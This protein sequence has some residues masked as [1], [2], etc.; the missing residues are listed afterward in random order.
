MPLPP[1]S[2]LTAALNIGHLS[3]ATGTGLILSETLQRQVQHVTYEFIRLKEEHFGPNSDE[4]GANEW[5]LATRGLMG[6]VAEG[7]ARDVSEADLLKSS[8]LAEETLREIRSLRGTHHFFSKT[9]D[10][11]FA[12]LAMLG[13]DYD[14]FAPALLWE[15]HKYREKRDKEENEFLKD[16]HKYLAE[17]M[18]IVNHVGSGQGLRPFEIECR[19]KRDLMAKLQARKWKDMQEFYDLVG[20]RIIVG[21]QSEVDAA[22]AFLEGAFKVHESAFLLNQGMLHV[23]KI[24]NIE[25][26]ISVPKIN[27]K[28]HRPVSSAYHRTDFNTR[29]YRGKHINVRRHTRENGDNHPTAEF[30]VVSLGIWEWGN[31]QRLIAYKDKQIPQK[32]KNAISS[33]LRSAA[34]YIVSCEEGKPMGRLPDLGKNI[35]ILNHIPDEGLRFDVFNRISDIDSLMRRYR[36]NVV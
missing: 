7:L 36:A 34:D 25:T 23:F 14:H 18:S 33:Y 17:M 1:L 10:G 31:I 35:L 5:I 27:R 12:A 20:L 3:D 19:I 2:E 4:I 16:Y 13:V 15:L 32:V 21:S 24:D 8:Q 22:V 11:F 28:R 26:K 9:L 6:F 29:G 30:Q